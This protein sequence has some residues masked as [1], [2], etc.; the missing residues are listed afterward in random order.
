MLGFA[1]T[2]TFGL[3]FSPWIGPTLEPFF[4]VLHRIFPFARGVFED[5]VANFWCASNVVVKWKTWFSVV[6]MARVSDSRSMLSRLEANVGVQIATLATLVALLPTIW[7]LLYSSYTLRLD[8]TSVRDAAGRKIPREMN[9]ST[10][11]PTINLLPMAL[12]T[13]SLSFFLFSFQVHEKSI[14]LPLMPLT[15]MM[16]MRGGKESAGAANEEIW[17]WG[18]LINNVAVFRCVSIEDMVELRR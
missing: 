2:A 11:P 4:W 12:F 10:L 8:P 9:P 7:I 6:G 18:V 15:V 14:L 13:S 3:M 5:K 1:T 16:A 17:E